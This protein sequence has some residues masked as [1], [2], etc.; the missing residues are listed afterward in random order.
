[1]EKKWSHPGDKLRRI[2]PTSL[3][4]TELLAVI[5]GIGYKGQ[6]AKQIT[7]IVIDKYHS[8]QGLMGKSIND[9]MKIKGL[10]EVKATRIAATFEVARR[11]VKALEKE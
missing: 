6:T 9:L 5:L 3:T 4:D 7:D 10:K 2:G 8:I 11:I 1:M